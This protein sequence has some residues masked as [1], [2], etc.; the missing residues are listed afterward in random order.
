MFM[1][2]VKLLI[3]QFIEIWK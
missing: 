2:F 1:F 3:S